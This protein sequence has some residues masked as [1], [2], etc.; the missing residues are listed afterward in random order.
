MLSFSQV[1]SPEQLSLGVFR[2]TNKWPVSWAGCLTTRKNDLLLLELALQS[3][4]SVAI[5]CN[6]SQH[7]G[8]GTVHSLQHTYVLK[9]VIFS[10]S[11]LPW[12][13]LCFVYSLS[14]PTYVN[15][16]C[17]EYKND[18]SVTV[19]AQTK[20]LPNLMSCLWWGSG[21]TGSLWTFMITYHLLAGAG[22]LWW[23]ENLSLLREL[24]YSLY[25][26]LSRKRVGNIQ[27]Y[28][29]RRVALGYKIHFS[30][31]TRVLPLIQQSCLCICALLCMTV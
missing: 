30:F 7:K 9:W 16:L 24:S 15:I 20:S 29:N 26:F 28:E 18:L 19:L 22:V 21:I 1:F 8:I 17:L 25:L 12:A 6:N 10:I 27:N 3:L 23:K 4:H 14:S 2:P 5:G 31:L 11:F 13:M